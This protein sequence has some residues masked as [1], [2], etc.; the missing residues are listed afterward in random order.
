MRMTASEV[1]FA[2]HGTLIGPDVEANGIS[3]NSRT[4]AAGQVFVAAVS[5]NH[6]TLPTNIEVEFSVG[7]VSFKQN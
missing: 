5:Y 1:A 4:L 6:L 2:A 7:G 3:F